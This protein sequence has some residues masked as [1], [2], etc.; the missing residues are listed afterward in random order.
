M[1]SRL[2]L[3]A[4]ALSVTSGCAVGRSSALLHSEP[5]GQIL[6]NTAQPAP[7]LSPAPGERVFHLPEGFDAWALLQESSQV[8]GALRREVGRGLGVRGAGE[9]WDWLAREPVTLRTFAPRTALAYLLREVF[10]GGEYVTYPELKRRSERFL[11]LVVM[12]P[13]GYLADALSGAPLQRMGEVTLREG[14]VVAGSYRVGSLYLSRGG[15]FFPVDERLRQSSYIPLGELG[16]EKDLVN[17]ALDGAGDAFGE[18]ALALVAFLCEPGR[19]VKG[20]EQLPAAVVAMLAASPEYL[21]HYGNLPLG[22]QVRE[23]ARLSTH[24]LMLMGGGAGT[25]ARVLGSGATLPVLQLSERGMM[26]VRMVAVPAGAAGTALGEGMGALVLMSVGRG[27]PARPAAP[28]QTGPLDPETARKLYEKGMQEAQRAFPQ[29]F[30]GPPH[31]HHI[32]PRYLLGPANG[33][34]VPIDPAYHQLITNEFRRRVAYGVLKPNLD[35]VLRVMREV[36]SK[37]PLPGVHF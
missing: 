27:G 21:A 2:F 18:V 25:G 15:V 26:A 34:T 5:R 31:A 37:Y 14:I 19:A 12:R 29:L 30:G 32:H 13:D 11:P 33:P 22:E 20:L 6:V 16:L 7:E 8:Q 28:R 9:M 10:A 1:S 24:V 36:Y 23:A 35:D 4:L 17:T 3:L